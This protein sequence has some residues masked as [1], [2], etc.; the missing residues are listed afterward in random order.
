MKEKFNAGEIFT[1]IYMTIKI[2][3]K[4]TNKYI[5]CKRYYCALYMQMVQYLLTLKDTSIP[6]LF[7]E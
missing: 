2:R 5:K 6:E 1:A 3:I 7:Y 4:G